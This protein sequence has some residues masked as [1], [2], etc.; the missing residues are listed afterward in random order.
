MDR[1]TASRRQSVT[2]R[3][4]QLLDA[5]I[6]VMSE[7]GISGATT[8]AITERAGVPHGVFHYCFDSK[9]ALLHA[10]L[11]RENER[12]LST[13]LRLDPEGE[14]LT[15]AL[16]TAIHAQLAR[17]RAE[18]K[19]FLVLAEL[20]VIARTD[21]TL[22]DLALRDHARTIDLIAEQLGRWQRHAPP[23]DLRRWAAVILAGVEGL[24]DG[25]LTTRDDELT[26]AAASLFASAVAHSMSADSR[27]LAS[28]G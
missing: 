28:D 24:I 14:G 1:V 3:R 6:D 17:V 23:A 13:A 26:N 4:E 12:A 7:H 18:P 2:D 16:P 9:A 5:A 10:L 27:Q 19:Q 20:T 8:R 22:T 11:T 21:P 15:E 25:W